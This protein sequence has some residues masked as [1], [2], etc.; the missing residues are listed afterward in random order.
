M[1]EPSAPPRKGAQP[2]ADAAAKAEALIKELDTEVRF[3]ELTG[4]WARVVTW[5]GVVLSLF[6]IYTAGFGVLLEIKHR[7]IHLA[8]V[9]GLI[10][11]TFPPLRRLVRQ[12]RVPWYDVILSVLAAGF[13]VWILWDFDNLIQ[14]SGSPT[15]TDLFWGT[16][17]ILVVLEAARRAVGWQLPV[18]GILFLLYAYFGPYFPGFLAHRGYSW[19][20][21]V[22]HLYL[23]TEG[24]YGIPV[25]V[26]ATY[27]FHFV[28]FGVF[29]ARTGLGQLFIDLATVLAGR[30]A[31]GPAK[32]SIV[33]SGLLGMISGSSI[34]NTVTT[35][36]FTIPMMKKIGYRPQF[37]GAVEATASTGGQITPPIMGAAAFVMAE[38]LGV[39]YTTI[40]AAAVCPALLHYLG[41]Y[42]Q[43]HLEARRYGLRGL[44]REEMPD[45]KE[46][47]RARGHNLLPLVILVYLL[48]SGRTPFIA[49]FWGIIS[50]VVVDFLL[51]AERLSLKVFGIGV[52]LTAA[53]AALL[54]LAFGLEP[55]KAAFWGGVAAIGVGYA[56]PATHT[57]FAQIVDGLDWG[58]RYALSVG[59]ACACVGFVL[60]TVSLTGVGFKFAVI[61]VDL[62][63]SLAE[64]LMPLDVFGWGIFDGATLFITLVFVGVACIILGAGVPTTAN[65]IILV[66]IA[67]PALQQL[68]VPQLVAHF[69]VLYY[70]I[71]ADVTP[72]VALAAAAGAG[73]AGS[74]PFKTGFTA[75]RL[76][77]AKALVPFVFVYAPIILVVTPFDPTQHVLSRLVLDAVGPQHASLAWW[78]EFLNVFG[79]AVLGVMALGAVATRF[80]FTEM[81]RL[82]QIVLFLAVFGMITPETYSSFAGIAVYVVV[83]LVNRLRMRRHGVR[84][85]V[86]RAA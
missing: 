29:A 34:A 31:G 45:I 42:V 2:D 35:G 28:L 47:V 12:T 66:V 15:T 22:D 17:A 18:L 54:H 51:G 10:F 41:V 25:G 84:S 52:A 55:G 5:V 71:L 73:I 33:S 36:A 76:A 83:V 9:M 68:G 86:S 32:V 1:S 50:A 16:V 75:F 44:T 20:R 61:A 67:A 62:A 64:A 53:F 49:A 85:S 38:F 63:R 6:H 57:R 58:A 82:E 14:R 39:P 26:V 74:D 43:V 60:G 7:A 56:V 27:V 59:A 21:M 69:F 81:T 77:A 48:L 80:I 78:A 40:I 37:A 3:R 24:I 65:Y 70:G 23:T 11:L 8:F 46:V 13:S 79:T 30:L 72:P 19:T 4:F